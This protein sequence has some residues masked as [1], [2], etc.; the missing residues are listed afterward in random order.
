[1]SKQNISNS[2][3]F[4]ISGPTFISKSIENKNI[5]NEK[6]FKI[7]MFNSSY[8]SY[9]VNGIDAHYKFLTLVEKILENKK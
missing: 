5:L 3:K 7:L 4:V 8:N 6:K 9:T 1:M 2:K